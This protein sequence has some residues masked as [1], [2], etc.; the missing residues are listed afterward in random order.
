MAIAC[1]MRPVP[2]S[3]VQGPTGVFCPSA[4]ASS[5]WGG[6]QTTGVDLVGL[7]V[8]EVHLPCLHQMC[9]DPLALRASPLLPG[10]HR[11]LVQPERRHDGLPGTPVRQQCQHRRHHRG[12]RAQPKERCPCRRA[13]GASARPTAIAPLLVTMDADGPLPAHPSGGAVLVRAELALRVH[14]VCSPDHGEWPRLFRPCPRDPLFVSTPPP[15]RS[16]GV[17]PP[18][19]EASR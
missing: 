8:L 15:S 9:V 6:V 16:N 7:H 1:H 14:G 11:A 10:G 18:A 4:P 13:K 17:V 19:P 3:G 5:M 12:R 2:S